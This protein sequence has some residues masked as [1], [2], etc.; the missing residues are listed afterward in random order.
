M[1]EVSTPTSSILDSTAKQVSPVN[2]VSLVKPFVRDGASEVPEEHT[3]MDV[4]YLTPA[5]VGTLAAGGTGLGRVRE[6]SPSPVGRISHAEE[7]FSLDINE[8]V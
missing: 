1:I 6:A 8:P 5:V 3:S 2:P 7:S 4:E